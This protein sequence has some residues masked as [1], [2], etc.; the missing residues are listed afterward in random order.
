MITD[1]DRSRDDPA[2]R[3]KFARIARRELVRRE[4]AVRLLAIMLH[5]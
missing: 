2:R 5:G 1:V 3:T 4:Q